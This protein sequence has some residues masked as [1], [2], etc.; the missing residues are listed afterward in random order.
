[1]ARGNKK[2]NVWGL[3]LAV[4][5]VLAFAAIGFMT[6]QSYGYS[7]NDEKSETVYVNSADDL[8]GIGKS[9]YNNNFYLENDITIE[10]FSTL[11]EA[12]RPFIGVFDGMGHTLTFTGEVHSALIGY[13]GE[14]GI[15]RNLNIALED[16]TVTSDFIGLLAYENEGTIA[17]CTVSGEITLAQSGLASVLAA[18]NRG[19][20]QRVVMELTVTRP[21]LEAEHASSVY[22]GLCAYNYG[23][24]ENI[25]A[26][27]TT[28]VNLQETEREAVFKQGAKNFGVGS[29]FGVDMG[30]TA[31]G[32]LEVKATQYLSDMGIS[33]F[34]CSTD[35][36]ELLT[37]DYI[38]DV[39]GFDLVSTWDYHSG[40]L[41]LRGSV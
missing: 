20:I 27:G 12:D 32:L 37:L 3:V 25:V 29:V 41:A 9:F 1:M 17:D 26:Y 19:A 4:L 28:F 33:D 24:L 7:F 10:S 5:L 30:G 23:S 34:V 38:A 2:F 14:G 18:V 11:T 39:L 22:G 21:A 35:I 6:A 13:I 31:S 16:C 15:I 8:K 36:D 40:S